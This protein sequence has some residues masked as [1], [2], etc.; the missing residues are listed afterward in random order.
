LP[1][2]GR[3]AGDRL[4]PQAT[5]C[6]PSGL[7]PGLRPVTPLAEVI[8]NGS[9]RRPAAPLPELDHRSREPFGE[10][11]PSPGGAICDS[12]G[13]GG[14]GGLRAPG[15]RPHNPPSPGGAAYGR[16]SAFGEICRPSGAWRF[17]S[18][19]FLGLEDHRG[20]L[21]PGYLRPPLRGWDPA[22][23]TAPGCEDESSTTTSGRSA[24][25]ADH[26]RPGRGVTDLRT[27]PLALADGLDED[28]GVGVVGRGSGQD[29][30]EEL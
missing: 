1:P 22:H 11:D 26:R 29:D 15:K 14:P 27:S 18:P 4:R 13:Q 6:R 20:H 24:A 5:I 30:D 7:K 17:F 19:P 28:P 3:G 12:L 9:G 10:L 21:G 23:R 2:F 25:I 16:P 8:R